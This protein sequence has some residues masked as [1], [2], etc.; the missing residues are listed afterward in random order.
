M[1]FQTIY[2]IS[3]YKI[4]FIFPS[5]YLYTVGHIYYL[6]LV[7]GLTVLEAIF[8]VYHFTL[9]YKME[10]INFTGMLPSMLVYSNTFKNT[11]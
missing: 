1:Q 2:F 6:D 7:S 3:L 9:L 4:L 5:R 11:F 8:H 10:S